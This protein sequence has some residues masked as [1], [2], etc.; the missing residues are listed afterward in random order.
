MGTTKNAMQKCK[1][2]KNATKKV[3]IYLDF[4]YKFYPIFQAKA[5]KIPHDAPMHDNANTLTF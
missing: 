1:K 4:S 5:G 2:K 3:K